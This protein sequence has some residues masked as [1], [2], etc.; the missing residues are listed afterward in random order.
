[1]KLSR[2]WINIGPS[3]SLNGQAANNPIV[4]GRITD[5]AL[6]RDGQRV[7]AATA[8]GGVWRS[9]DGGDS[10]R[11]L[12]D[13]LR[14]APQYPEFVDRDLAGPEQ[15]ASALAIGAVACVSDDP[16]RVFV[17]TGEYTAD[18]R[19]YRGIGILSS[20][21]GGRTWVT[22]G[23]ASGHDP[24]TGA[25][26]F[27][28][29]IDPGNPD[30]VMAATSRGLYRRTSDGSG[31]FQWEQRRIHTAGTGGDGLREFT[32][33]VVAA[34][35]GE[36]TT[37]FMAQRGGDVFRSQD[38]G[39]TWQP[40]AAGLAVAAD[41]I[42]TLAVKYDDAGIL[43]ALVSTG[44]LLR[45]DL[46][47][48]AP[49]WQA[50]TGFPPTVNGSFGGA[51]GEIHQAIVVDPTNPNRVF[52]GGGR[53]HNTSGGAAAWAAAL[54][55]ADIGI[56][57][58]SPQMAF[59]NIGR[60][61]PSYINALTVPVDAATRLWIAGDSGV[62]ATEQSADAVVTFE[63][64]NTGLIAQRMYALAM[65]PT[66]ESVLL[67]GTEGNGCIRYV[68][69]ELWRAAY[70]ADTRYHKDSAV[71]LGDVRGTAINWN[72]P[73]QVLIAVAPSSTKVHT[74]NATP[75]TAALFIKRS[76]GGDDPDPPDSDEIVL[77]LDAG[78]TVESYSPM[79]A[80]PHVTGNAVEA[81]RV[82]FGSR[83]L[84]ISDDFGAN[85]DRAGAALA[86]HIRSI[87][88]AAFNRIYVGC[89]EGQVYRFDHAAGVWIPTRL[90]TQPGLPAGPGKINQPV[91]GLSVDPGSPDRVYL[92]FGGI[93]V[94]DRLW[95]YD[96]AA[97]S[98]RHNPTAP[99][100]RQLPQVQAL[101]IAVDPTNPATLYVGTDIGVWHSTDSGVQWD[102]FNEGLPE[103]PVHQLLIHGPRRLLRAA[104]G[105]RGVYELHLDDDT[106]DVRLF[107]RDHRLDVGLRTNYGL[108][109]DDPIDN[110][111]TPGARRQIADADA[112]SPDIKA[113]AP[114]VNIHYQIADDTC[115]DYR[116]FATGISDESAT[117][118]IDP[119]IVKTRLYVQIHN[120]GVNRANDVRVMLLVARIDGGNFPDLPNDYQLTLQRGSEINAEG[121][122]TVGQ[123]TLDDVRAGV[124]GIAQFEL[125]SEML[126]TFGPLSAGD[127][128]MLLC[129]LHHPDDAFEASERAVA[130]LV[131]DEPK[132]T[133]RKITTADLH[134]APAV[135]AAT[136]PNR[137]KPIGPTG[138]RRGQL[139]TQTV[140][141]GRVP[142]IAIAPGGTRIYIA[143]ANAGIWRSD[144][145]GITWRSLMAQSFDR[146]PPNV[147]GHWN[148]NGLHSLAIGAIALDPTNPDRLYVGTGEAHHGYMGVGP[149]LTADGGRTWAVP[150]PTSTS[151]VGQG[152]YGLAV[153]PG[154]P[155]R[156]VAATTRGVFRREPAAHA[157]GTYRWVRKTNFTGPVVAG[158]RA[159]H[160][161]VAR[162]G[163][164][165]RFFA[166]RTH[167]H[168][169]SAVPD[170]RGHVYFSADGHLWREIPDFP[171]HAEFNR[172][173]LGV[174]PDN[175]NMVYA[176]DNKGRVHR[177]ERSGGAW[178]RWVTIENI[179]GDFPN[180]QGW[181]NQAIAVSPSSLGTIVI[182]GQAY[183]EWPWSVGAGAVYRLR[184]GGDRVVRSDFI[185]NSLHP[186]VHKLIYP[187]NNHRE[188][189]CGCDGGVYFAADADATG[190]HV[191]VD[192][193][194]GIQSL[195]LN[196]I[197]RHPSTENVL[198]AGTQD[199]GGIR[200]TGD[201]TW[202]HVTPG[203]GGYPVVNQTDPHRYI[204]TYTE[205]IMRGADHG[206]VWGWALIGGDLVKTVAGIE[207]DEPLFYAPL[208]R[209]LSGND[210]LLAFGTRALW[211]SNNFGRDWQSIP[212]GNDSDRLGPV[213]SGD[214]NKFNRR[215]WAIRSILFAR[216][217]L[218]YIGLM[219]G[220]VYRYTQAAETWS[221]ARIDNNATN[222][223]VPPD[224][225]NF[226]RQAFPVR[227]I[228]LDPTDANGTS[229]FVAL[230]GSA[231][232]VS[233]V[234]GF[235]HRIG[236][237]WHFNG[238]TSQWSDRSGAG[239]TRIPNSQANALIVN[240]NNDSHLYVGLD[241]G[242]WRT[243]NAQD[244]APSWAMFSTDLPD[245]AVLDF[246]WHNGGA[247]GVQLLRAATYGFGA[248]EHLIGPANVPRVELFLRNSP[249]DGAR[250]GVAPRYGD[251]H[252]DPNSRSKKAT[253]FGGSPDVKVD[254]PDADGAYQFAND[255]TPTYVEYVDKLSDNA[256]HV[257]VAEQPII[258]R[259][260]VQVHN[261]G[262]VTGEDVVIQVLIGS[263][264][265]ED[266]PA[267][268]LTTLQAD[269]PLN[270]DNWSFVG[271]KT[272]GNVQVG[273]PQI[274]RF[275]LPPA[276]LPRWSELENPGRRGL[277][278]L[279]YQKSGDTFRGNEPNVAQLCN[280]HRQATFKSLKI[281]R[282][283]GR[284]PRAD[285]SLPPFVPNL[286][287]VSVAL[288][289][290]R[291]ISALHA[292]LQ[293][294]IDTAGADIS[295][296]ERRMHA[297]AARAAAMLE[298]GDAVDAPASAPLP[299]GF[300][301]F[302]LLGS[303]AWNLPDFIDLLSPQMGWITDV[304]RRGTPDAHFSK[305]VVPTSQFVVRAGELA[306]AQASSNA[307]KEKIQAFTM[308]LLCALATEVTCNPILRGLQ[309]GRS[310]IDWDH[311][312][313]GIDDIL[314]NR[315]ISEQMLKDA[316]AQ[317][318]WR[319]WFPDP[320]DIPDALLNGF[321][322]AINEVYDPNAL[323]SQRFADSQTGAVDSYTI[324]GGDLREGYELF[325]KSMSPGAHWAIWWLLLSPIIL[326]GPLALILARYAMPNARRLLANVTDDN[327][328]PLDANEASW[329]EL[330]QISMALGGVMPLIYAM[331]LWGIVPRQNPYFVQALLFGIARA[332][333]SAGALA[334]TDAKP[335]LRWGLFFTLHTS[336]DLYFLV[337]SIIAWARG[338]PGHANMY[339]LQW[340]PLMTAASSFIFTLLP[341]L[342][343][344]K[345]DWQF[346]LMWAVYTAG[347]WFGLG[348][349]MG[350]VIS[351]GGGLVGLLKNR[352]LDNPE[353]LDFLDPSV[354]PPMAHTRARAFDAQVMWEQGGTALENKRYPSGTRAV[355]RIWWTGDG[356]MTIKH[357]RDN[358]VFNDGSAETPIALDGPL[359]PQQIAD[360]IKA[361]LAGIEAVPF[362]T[363]DPAY[364]LPAPQMLADPG[365]TGLTWETHA[366]ARELFQPVGKSAD[367]AYLL[368]H[369]P[370]SALTTPV[371]IDE[372]CNGSEQV[373]L[374]PSS[375][376][377]PFDGT[378]IDIAADLASMLCMGA[379]PSVNGAD[380]TV[381]DLPNDNKLGKVYQVFRQWNLDERRVN[382][383]K[384]L[385]AGGAQSEKGGHPESADPGMRAAPDDYVSRAPEGEAIATELGW[386]EAFKAWKAIAADTQADGTI[387]RAHSAS[388]TIR[389]PE[390]QP[391]QAT[392]RELTNAMR[393][394]FD[395]P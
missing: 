332:A 391:R 260:Y 103:V 316:P 69:D 388:P 346:W 32:S 275:D 192:R 88:F 378:G 324:S 281:R 334:T 254:A 298:Q 15:G 199:N 126:A 205:H 76:D 101:S 87:A 361:G 154:N 377:D 175:R 5:L 100:I 102:P 395:L 117:V 55:R 376:T 271:R 327:G 40:A 252:P 38:H 209:C 242:V 118:A 300:S 125:S 309:A 220:R 358:V 123:A 234:T 44:Q 380:I 304:L 379:T 239:G 241:T 134:P 224:F 257:G 106:P 355:V 186:D 171:R 296:T 338:H 285:S 385:I 262:S 84:W 124:P 48:A 6:S 322:A 96:G 70:N 369:S 114:D 291:K 128:F 351:N 168:G 81:D 143:T 246:E 317:S 83:Q 282:Y 267:N 203:D 130:T 12:M 328:Q 341:H 221:R 261:R 215:Q 185:G 363:D 169:T 78:D 349:P 95:F 323:R 312:R 132:A 89:M 278:V 75:K 47:V 92:T 71:H 65:H 49:A 131:R 27:A 68:G 375:A 251:N 335:E 11:P 136:V 315:W 386:L 339:M 311:R 384:M 244:A 20:N 111:A 91:T 120:R 289:T 190:D 195:E 165:T 249:V 233:H 314:T 255:Y 29:T 365:D 343:G 216:P 166:A 24:L 122:Q 146:N 144:D 104:T 340:L 66:Y 313:V 393:F 362:D 227:S 7:Y 250:E 151:L 178:G 337:R 301:K 236:R 63:S 238:A 198:F 64:K 310:S 321:A 133:L 288:L 253:F 247:G 232:W 264:P 52:F 237:V 294:K 3:A 170:I 39:A 319:S 80:N 295:P 152:F 266:L 387:D 256:Q 371:G 90:D 187:P 390:Q 212:N 177:A 392:A 373:R 127:Q 305:A 82:A 364:A 94:Y 56:V 226:S 283:T 344:W 222:G 16:D 43:Y 167:N 193:N 350:A 188:L 23:I 157:P 35:S 1:M 191:F 225:D 394:L 17:G 139:P 268:Y 272:V 333:V 229:I 62:F 248:W 383:W 31:G 173:T 223:T 279:A 297:M 206:G 145:K 46:S 217:N 180:K 135:P 105:G 59:A 308:G 354:V 374:H 172:I 293:A 330:Y 182:G 228:I 79:V 218:I 156:V 73:Y 161:V 276:L 113:D 121:W 201:E 141:G 348:M 115:I 14:L 2:K 389:L 174:K 155:E 381:A 347:L 116:I 360:Q 119:A 184:I 231:R 345:E 99:A 235:G 270:T 72:D 329:Y 307:E 292:G 50:V 189:W 36:T 286:L 51:E 359:T 368:R 160:V 18:N 22:E 202:L 269:L 299:Q 42:L 210:N 208:V 245:T 336:F 19:G 148:T 67:G 306:L 287:P 149:T 372:T 58:G 53:S 325:F 34:R 164:V 200:Y 158:D 142:D 41:D 303:T 352:R 318:R 265:P 37:W 274:V 147:A 77:A 342:A 112:L 357:D 86:S 8:G 110:N 183:H 259:I 140:V 214:S 159:T 98:S 219:N 28:L 280:Q 150:E 366:A 181:Y 263:D 194:T 353:L 129:L 197:D 33:S 277:L 108:P 45:A 61:V 13:G 284:I 320:S 153:D 21:D 137:W 243:Q 176:L 302:A 109:Q 97:W 204:V 57:G 93:G 382:E 162:S 179:P 163:G 54:Y 370:R 4:G 207:N 326:M 331:V 26:V 30:R 213:L 107:V 367:K 74:T 258:N 9:D 290:R 60:S 240:P 10:W 196:A 230:G 356:D 211:I 138:V 85:W 25:I 273:R